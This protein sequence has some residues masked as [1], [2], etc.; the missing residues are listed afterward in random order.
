MTLHKIQDLR[1]IAIGIAIFTQD[2]LLFIIISYCVKPQKEYTT[3]III[4]G[5][6]DSSSVQVVV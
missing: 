1:Y 3:Q 5:V 2:E 4:Q 6:G